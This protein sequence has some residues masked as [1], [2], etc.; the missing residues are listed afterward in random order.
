MH[1]LLSPPRRRGL[2]MLTG[3][4]GLCASPP[5]AATTGPSWRRTTRSRTQCPG[6]P[7]T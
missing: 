1:W 7:L 2:S 5:A 4:W 6:A 3:W